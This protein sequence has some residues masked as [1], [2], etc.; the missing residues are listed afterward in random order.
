MWRIIP[1]V[2]GAVMLLFAAFCAFGFLAAF[3]AGADELLLWR[4][5]YTLGFTGCVWTALQFFAQAA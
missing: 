1:I 3:E 2:G 4:I 5:G